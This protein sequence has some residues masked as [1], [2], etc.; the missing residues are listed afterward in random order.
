MNKHIPQTLK[1]KNKNLPLEKLYEI[2]SQ[3]Y[4]QE[5]VKEI[6]NNFFKGEKE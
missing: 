3:I 4:P 5:V 6:M 2:L 1:R